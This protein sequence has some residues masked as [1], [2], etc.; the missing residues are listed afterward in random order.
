[1]AG[2]GIVKLQERHAAALEKLFKDW[3]TRWQECRECLEEIIPATGFFWER[4][5]TSRGDW[6]TY[7]GY[8]LGKRIGEMDAALRILQQEESFWAGREDGN[9]EGCSAAQLRQPGADPVRTGGGWRRRWPCTRSKKPSAWSWA[10]R[11]VW[12]VSYGNQALILQ[13]VGAAGGGAGAAQEGRSHLPGVG[14]QGRAAS[15][16]RQ[17]GADPEGVGAAGG[18]AGAAQEGGSHLPGVGQQ[19]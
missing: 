6:L 12:Q 19:G 4:G 5:E 9:G 8:A 3:E 13:G 2:D 14:Q 7:W 15:Q 10:T 16:L 1:M 11:M 18:G 17:P